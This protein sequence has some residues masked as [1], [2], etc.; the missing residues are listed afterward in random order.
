MAK[1]NTLEKI[2]N[3]GIIAHID[4]G[5]TTVTERILFYTGRTH[6]LGEVHDGQAVMDYLVQEQERGITITSAATTCTWLDNDIHIIDTP[7][8]VDFT[9]EVERCLR[10]LDGAV[11]VF[12]A[13]GGVE[14]QSETVWHQADKYHIPRIAFVNKMDRIGADFHGTVNQMKEKLG[15]FPLVLQLPFGNEAN[16]KGV[17]DLIQNQVILWDENTLGITYHAEEIP[18]ENK[19]EAFHYRDILLEKLAENDDEVLNKYLSGLPIPPEHIRQVV[20]RLTLGMKATPVL[21]G[22]ALKNKGIQPVLD[23]VTHYLPS[24]VDVPSVV[25]T[26]P[27]TNQEERRPCSEKAPFTAFAFK[28]ISDEEKRKFTFLR[29]YSGKVHAESEVY[30]ATKRSTER[31]ARIFRL[32]ANKRQRLTETTA[33]DIVAVAGLKNTTTGDTLCT[34]GNPIVLESIDSYRPVISVAIEPKTRGDF[35]RLENA[36]AKLVDEDPTF[37]V[38]H[39]EDSDQIVI[40]GM[41]ELHLEV[42]VTR[43]LQD[44]KVNVTVGRPQ[45]VYRETI[46]RTVDVEEVF[47]K[48]IGGAQ[49]YGRVKLKLE[50]LKRGSGFEFVNALPKGLV[51]FAFESAIHDG[52]QE[53]LLSGVVGGYPVVDIRITVVDA[54]YREG[55]S[56]AVAYKV[57]TAMAIKKGSQNA[58]PILLEPIMSVDVVVPE[59]FVGDVIGDL[60]AR[61]GKIEKIIPKGKASLL[62]AL[63]PLRQ[64]FGYSTNLRSASQGR[65]TFSMQFS[66]YDRTD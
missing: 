12:C 27:L 55:S 60:N 32:H 17:I 64:M 46:T 3:I 25:G 51:P 43:L 6:K 52:A 36:L 30:N 14:P 54:T 19:E 66:H 4:A 37:N 18:E 57:A 11:V 44:F 34:S 28:V 13:V 63:V 49:N 5:K 31:F 35:E 33:G 21:C 47:D 23:A 10:V 2:R 22:A 62:K 50:P 61:R 65:G 42:L 15:A 41:G 48:E 53:G 1:I 20:R 38:K 7:G 8:H 40:S 29:I 24:P 26:N 16:F 9:I 39:D 59:S 58:H 56:T 45:V